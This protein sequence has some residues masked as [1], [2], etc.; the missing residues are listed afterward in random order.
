MVCLQ[1]P[2]LAHLEST[3]TRVSCGMPSNASRQNLIMHEP[4]SASAPAAASDSATPSIANW[5]DRTI[6]AF[7][8]KTAFF[9]KVEPIFLLHP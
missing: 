6:Q 1:F 2:H 7:G 5:H 9:D 4:T 8:V 3:R